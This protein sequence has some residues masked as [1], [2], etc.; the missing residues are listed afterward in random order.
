MYTKLSEL[1]NTT[2]GM[3]VLRNNSALDSGP[4]TVAGADWFTFNGSDVANLYVHGD[5]YVG[6]GSNSAQL[7]VCSRNARMYYL[8]RQEGKIT[9][10]RFLKIR[11]EGYSRNNST[12]SSYK[13]TWELFLFDDGG[14]FLNLV[15]PPS[16]SSY[17]GTNSLT[18]GDKTYAFTVTVS[19][20]VTYSFL[21]QDDGSFVV[22]ADEYPVATRYVSFGTAEFSTDVIRRVSS[23]KSSYI[24]WDADIPDGTSLKIYS[25]LSNGEYELCD[26]KG[27][28]A[29]LVTG[30][31][32][33]AE[34]L[35]LKVE[36][37]TTVLSISPSLK[38]VHVQIFDAGDANVVF[39]TFDPGNRNSIQRAAGDITVAY[40]G[41]GSLIGEGGPVLAFEHTFTPKELDPKNNPNDAEHIEIA[42][43]VATGGL[44]RIYYT[45]TR[46]NEHIILSNI[47]AVGTLTR[48]D[49]I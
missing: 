3:D 17:I 47:T 5:S 29:G 9:T 19:T 25:K 20:P 23:V 33:T 27:S 12:S 35:Y 49:D 4:D 13:L 34:T 14:M 40:D 43:I 37:E 39:L 42:D 15:T 18:C 41:S 10:T 28:I 44:T 31:N 38:R 6:F 32:L 45:D 36:M 30:T 8:Y 46:E 26:R 1:L 16:S 7:Q 2:D 22:T 48:I 21:L 11:W 24:E